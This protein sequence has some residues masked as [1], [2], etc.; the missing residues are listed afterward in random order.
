MIDSKKSYEYYL[1]ADRIALGK[2]RKEG[3]MVSLFFPDKVYQ[4]QRYLRK[5]EYLTNCKKGLYWKLV[6]LSCYRRFKN[7]SEKLGFS[8]PLNSCGPGLS[9]AHIG[10]IVINEGARI[11]ANCRIHVCVNIGTAAGHKHLAPLIGDNVY[12]APGVK[13][14]GDIRIANG[15]ALSANSVVNKSFENE[16]MV[17]GGIPAKEIK[18]FDTKVTNILATDLIEAGID[19]KLIEGKAAIEA[20]AF[21]K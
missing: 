8:I 11:G 6:R 12:I 14:Y 17:V 10:P 3:F 20:N 9:I 21:L 2:K 13:M 7:L 19:L 4:F 5:L 15:V 16:H 18:E 1:E